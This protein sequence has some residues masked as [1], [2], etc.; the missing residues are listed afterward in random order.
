MHLHLCCPSSLAQ[1]SLPSG[2]AALL[3]A[4][5]FRPAFTRRTPREGAVS[6]SPGRQGLYP[7][8]ICSYEDQTTSAAHPLPLRA[9]SSEQVAQ[10]PCLRLS[11]HTAQAAT[12]ALWQD[13]L[14]QENSICCNFTIRAWSYPTVFCQRAHQQDL[15]PPS[16]AFPL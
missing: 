8:W 4:S 9:V 16:S 11:P 15:S 14:Q 12:N 2:L 5:R 13:A 10:E 7:A 3:S 1:A 6:R